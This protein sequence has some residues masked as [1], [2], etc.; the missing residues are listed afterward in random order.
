MNKSANINSNS[1]SNTEEEEI[2]LREIIFKYIHYWKWFIASVILFLL[3][4]TLVYLCADRKYEVTT[5]ILLKEDKGGGSASKA[6]MLGNLEDLGLLST[7]NNIDNEIAVLSSPNLIKQVVSSLNINATYYEDGIFRDTEI[8]NECPYIVQYISK[9]STLFAGEV[10]LSISGNSDNTID[11]GGNYT[12]IKDEYKI[13]SK[14]SNLPCLVNLPANAGQLLI[15]ERPRTKKDQEEDRYTKQDKYIVNIK[16]TLAQANA[17]IDEMQVTATT[18]QS[19]VLNIKLNIQNTEKGRDILEGIIKLY[20]TNNVND[21]NE[22]AQNTSK[23]ITERLKTISDELKD[24]ETSVVEYKKLNGIADIGQEAK[25]FMEQSAEVNKQRTSVETQLKT[26]ELI[27]NFIGK[28]DSDF[29]PIP[30]LSITDPGLAQLIANYNTSLLTYEQLERST[31]EKSHARSTAL[32]E[33]K[34]T[35]QSI[36]TSIDNV[37]KAFSIT[38]GEL[39]K[40]YSLMTDKIS[41]IPSQEQGLMEIMR[42]QQIKQSLY[43]YLL[44]MG[45]ETN[46]TIASTSDKAKII[47]DPISSSYPVSPKRNIIYLACFV[48]GIIVPVA[49][50]FIKDKLQINISSREELERLSNLN[51]IGEIMKKDSDEIMVVKPN[52]TTPIVELFRTLRNNIQFILDTS[53]KKVVL[54]TSTIPGEGKTFV[55]INTSLSFTLSDK[56]VLLIGMDIRNPKLAFEMGFTKGHGLTSYLSGDEPNWKSLLKNLK[57]YPNLDIL[58]AGV[59]PPNPNELLM[60][61]AMKHLL[62]EARELYD[63]IIIDSAPIGVVSD[64]FLIGNLADATVYVT[65]EEVTPKQAVNFVN[66]VYKDKKLPNMY[67][68]YNG[69]EMSK[70]KGRYGYGYTYGYGHKE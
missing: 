59:V 22:I 38:K 42:Q 25:L 28:K 52:R 29:K 63:I 3:I 15:T 49:V 6:G 53:D 31:N 4:G 24:I 70:N 34:L 1:F 16:S 48:V 11:I 21:N 39:D 50:I 5:A 44:Q 40:Q 12:Y 55:S 33:L 60:K 19:S 17:I 35:K 57:E 46:I 32:A 30:N 45:E 62:K 64:T 37:K 68:V 14:T 23:F 9:D 26:V 8:Y 43:L 20:N 51:V 47:T 56:K 54:I 13:D 69:V 61:P 18:K 2:D 65:R 67:L 7:T 27:E 36:Q 66:E 10:S 41:S 58:Q